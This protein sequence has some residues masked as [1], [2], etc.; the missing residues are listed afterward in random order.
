[1]EPILGFTD[2]ESSGPA[3]LYIHPENGQRL[4]IALHVMGLRNPANLVATMCHELAHVHLLADKRITGDAQD[5]EP[6]TDLVT[7]YFGAGI[8]TANSAFQFG[9]WQEGNY[10]GWSASRQGYLTEAQ[11]GY[12]LAC[13]CWFRGETE[14][15]WRHHLR[16]NIAYYFDDSMDF[17]ARTRDTPVPFDGA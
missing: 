11:F 8:F 9:Q 1:M 5:G 13:Y 17:L 16:E 6:L 14:A 15:G 3:V 10:G 12:A 2:R 7:V 4:M